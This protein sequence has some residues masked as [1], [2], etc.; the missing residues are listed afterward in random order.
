M[1]SLLWAEYISPE[2]ARAMVNFF[3]D[4][5]YSFSVENKDY[6]CTPGA[7][8]LQEYGSGISFKDLKQIDYETVSK[9]VLEISDDND[10]QETAE[11]LNRLYP[12]L[13]IVRSGVHRAVLDITSEKATKHL[14]VLELSKILKIDPSLM[15]GVGDSYNDYSLLSTCGF[16]VALENAPTQLKEIADFIV[17][18]V[19]ND[20]LVVAINKLDI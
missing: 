16:K 18:D 6:V 1:D 13:H 15:I 7:I 8:T 20:G 2:T 14:A 5:H 4:N 12:D 10:S 9:T 11:K 3:L 17:P 19:K